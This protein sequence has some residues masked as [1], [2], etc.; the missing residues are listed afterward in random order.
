MNDSNEKSEKLERA[1]MY[2]KSDPTGIYFIQGRPSSIGSDNHLK[3]GKRRNRN[4]MHN[5]FFFLASAILFF[6]K[7]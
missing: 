5:A 7:Q 1:S 6:Q 4:A 2:Q 3:K